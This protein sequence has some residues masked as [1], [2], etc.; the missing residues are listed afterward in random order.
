MGSRIGGKWALIEEG[1]R[2]QAGDRQGASVAPD[3]SCLET[4]PAE[5]T[6]GQG[7]GREP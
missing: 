6:G 5:G 4:S 3:R 2:K 7:P 1:L